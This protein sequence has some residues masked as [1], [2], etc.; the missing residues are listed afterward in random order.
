MLTD[1]T[2]I[3]NTISHIEPFSLHVVVETVR[4]IARKPCRIGQPLTLSKPSHK[5][6]PGAVLSAGNRPT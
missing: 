3:L 4:E 5:N 1:K 2:K 6:T